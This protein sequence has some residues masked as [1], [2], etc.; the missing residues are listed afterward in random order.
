[1]PRSS[2]NEFPDQPPASVANSI[3][4]IPQGTIKR[5]FGTIVDSGVEH[6]IYTVPAGKR[7]LVLA[8]SFY[9]NDAGANNVQLN[10]SFKKAGNYYLL[11]QRSA[12]AQHSTA[13]MVCDPPFFGEAGDVF[14]LRAVNP[15]GSE[16]TNYIMYIWEFPNTIGFKTY[17]IAP[18]V[19]GANV[20]MTVPAG[21]SSRLIGDT[22]TSA[23]MY[24][25]G[26][27]LTIFNG[28]GGARNYSVNVIPN[29][30]VLGATNQFELLTALANG[31]FKAFIDIAGMILTA[32]DS[33]V[34]TTNSG[35]GN[36]IAWCT[37]EEI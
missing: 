7:G 1:M 3:N 14:S 19:N 35:A 22:N 37:V 33:I 5:F 4:T 28:S 27:F 26:S 9:N 18:L 17:K 23:A 16:S 32:G 30:G 8:V 25:C 24:A 36:Q 11:F 13:T 34:V 29:G 2:I 6:D 31:S 21:K 10:C 15:S 20:L 12:L